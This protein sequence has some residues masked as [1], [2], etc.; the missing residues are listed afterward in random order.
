MMVAKSMFRITVGSGMFLMGWLFVSVWYALYGDYDYIK[1][2][3]LVAT[4]MYVSG[5]LI[6]RKLRKRGRYQ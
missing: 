1:L 6:E 4:T 2:W 3:M 5:W